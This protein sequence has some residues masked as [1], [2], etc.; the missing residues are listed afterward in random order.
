MS[1]APTLACLIAFAVTP[2][3][4]AA[5]P[6]VASDAPTAG[7]ATLALVEQWRHGGDDDAVFFGIPIEIEADREG[8][9]LVL[10]SQLN[11]VEVFAPAGEHLGSVGREGEGPGEFRRPMAMV[12]N[13]AGEAVVCAG[14]GARFVRLT[15]PEGTPAGEF[16]LGEQDGPQTG[17]WFV[18]DADRRGGNLLV[19]A[20]RS[21]FDQSTGTIDRVHFLALCDDTGREVARLREVRFQF[22]ISADETVRE[23][24]VMRNFLIAHALGPDGRTYVP[25]SR[26]EYAIEVYSPAGELERV[27]VRDGFRRPERSARTRARL[28]ALYETWVRNAGVEIGYEIADRDAVIQDLFVDDA[29]HLW[30]R[31]AASGRDLPPGGFLRLDE[32]GPEGRWLREVVVMGDYDP[33]DDTLHWL[34]DGR[35]AVLRTGALCKLSR[36]RDSGITYD[37][38]EQARVVEVIAC[39]L[40]PAD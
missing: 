30:V 8:R 13:G 20:Q 9:V 40:T 37:D 21:D 2:P 18:L 27:I 39:R 29:G 26:D 17:I 4:L 19:A 28:T 16:R 10:D 15:V 23:V 6:E 11:R 1:R 25:R 14:I 34:G 22:R 33:Q 32:F 36:W 31:H 38:E 5:A 35:V 24:E 12:V 7:R 3:A